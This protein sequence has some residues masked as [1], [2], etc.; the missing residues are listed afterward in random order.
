[1]SEATRKP[2]PRLPSARSPWYHSLND[3]IAEQE[4]ATTVTVKG[5]ATLPKA[6]REAAG[7]RSGDRVNVGVRSEGGVIVEAEK[8]RKTDKS[9][10]LG[11]EDMSRRR[12]I[13][14]VTTEEIMAMTRGNDRPFSIRKT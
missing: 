2:R 11:L 7:I 14:G 12:P 1:M 8:S 3:D 4:V 10:R 5:Q 9:Y 13:Q 6:V